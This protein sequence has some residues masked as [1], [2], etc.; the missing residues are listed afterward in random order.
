[1]T[2]ERG[3]RPRGGLARTNYD[4]V[5]CL[6]GHALAGDNLLI[7]K[8]RDRHPQRICKTCNRARARSRRERPT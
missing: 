8:W 3:P 4:K 6:R 2:V 7:Y 5:E 1:V